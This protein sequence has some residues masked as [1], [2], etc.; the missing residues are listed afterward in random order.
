M[1]IVITGIIA[2]VSML[3]AGQS[4]AAETDRYDRK[5]EH[6][7]AER[8]AARLGQLRGSIAPEARRSSFVSEERP[9]PLGF[10][11]PSPA[12]P[13]IEPAPISLKGQDRLTISTTVGQRSR[14]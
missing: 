11:L 9:A 14:W 13:E 5:I 6:A 4:I 12:R 8:A 7:A 10:G 3:A 2:A 1:R